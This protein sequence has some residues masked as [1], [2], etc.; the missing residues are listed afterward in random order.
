VGKKVV[1]GAVDG[2]KAVVDGGK[3]VIGKVTEGGEA[4]AK[5]ASDAV[6]SG[7]KKLKG[8]FSF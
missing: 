2:G 5:G 1:D 7:Y 3:K 6:K 4:I 8:L